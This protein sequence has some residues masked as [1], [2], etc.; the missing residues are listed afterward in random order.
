MARKR[1]LS[2]IAVMQAVFQREYQQKDPNEVLERNLEELAEQGEGDT[3]FATG[4][5][6]GVIDRESD[7][8]AAV[9]KHAPDW[10][11]ERMDP[12]ARA[13]LLLGGYEILFADDAP[14]AVVMNECIDIA[15]AYGGEE[16]SKFVN[17]VLNALANKK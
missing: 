4:L 6:Q 3:A 13:I 5:L 17:G 8:K 14:P 15:K 16:T 11:F 10:T 12:I 9:E 7:I 2:R 1:H